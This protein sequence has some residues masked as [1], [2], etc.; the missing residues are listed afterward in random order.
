MVVGV[1]KKIIISIPSAR[2]NSSSFYVLWNKLFLLELSQDDIYVI[3]FEFGSCNFIGANTT[4]L[5]GSFISYFVEN[6]KGFVRIET[7][8]MN[9]QVHMKL[10]NMELLSALDRKD[11]FGFHSKNQEVIPYREFTSGSQEKEV[12]DYLESDWLSK[13][14]LIFSKEVKSSVL[15]SIWE[16]FANAFEHS[17]SKSVHCCGTYDDKEKKLSLLVGDTGVGIVSSVSNFRSGQFTSMDALAWALVRGNSTYTSNIKLVGAAQ[18]R[19]LGLHLL[20]QLVDVNG[21]SLEIY[22]DNVFYKRE[23]KQDTYLDAPFE[24]FG[25][26]VRLTLNCNKNTA[27]YFK[28]EEVPIYF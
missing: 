4:A 23:Y 26:W 21:G 19:G 18:P 9:R 13:K 3:Q 28:D 12:I 25:S 16:I 11:G 6:F 15:S 1:I 8:T 2:D 10:R 22:T 20:T 14:R 5:I 7:N 24:V 27:Y 17:N